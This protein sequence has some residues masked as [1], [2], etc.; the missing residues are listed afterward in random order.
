LAGA[1]VGA[2]AIDELAS[3]DGPFSM[4]MPRLLGIGKQWGTR[5]R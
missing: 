5:I 1:A 3:P 4:F 2:V